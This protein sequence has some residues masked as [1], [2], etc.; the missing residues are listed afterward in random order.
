MTRRNEIRT[1][2]RQK[3]VVLIVALLLLLVTTFLGFSSMEISNLETRMA[4]SRELEELVFQT[5]EAAIE[6]ALDDINFISAA[7]L[8]SLG[9]SIPATAT[10]TYNWDSA[11]TATAQAVFSTD[12]ATQ[13]YSKRKGAGGIAT[14][15]YEIR[16]TATRTN[17][18]ISALHTQGVFVEGPSLQ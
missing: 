1:P 18:N 10:Y 14:F 9:G 5:A 4:T 6:T 12:V 7:Y 2:G 16:V 11:L 3:G 15:Y 17:T 13:G 8:A